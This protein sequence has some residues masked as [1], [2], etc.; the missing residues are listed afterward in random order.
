MALKMA[1]KLAS[2]GSRYER[3]CRTVRPFCGALHLLAAGRD[4]RHATFMVSEEA[5]IAVRAW[6]AM[7]FLLRYD[8]ER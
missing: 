2:W 6:Q 8:E 5:K 3:T 7:L 4:S 1:Q